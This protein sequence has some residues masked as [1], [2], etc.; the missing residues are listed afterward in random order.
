[1]PT[2]FYIEDGDYL[3]EESTGGITAH[4]KDEDDQSFTPVTATWTLT[5]ES[6]SVI[7]SREN[8]VIA[9]LAT[10]N[11]IVLFGDDLAFQSGESGNAVSRKLTIKGTYN[12]SDFGNGKPFNDQLTF[13]IFN[14]TAVP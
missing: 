9:S 11:T 1:M 4:F 2:E 7:N 13:P 10:N 12:S 5:D 6:G 8:I 14:L 3:V